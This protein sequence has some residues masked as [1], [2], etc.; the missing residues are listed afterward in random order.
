MG[1]FTAHAG[2]RRRAPRR[3]RPGL[4]HPQ[5]QERPRLPEDGLDRGRAG[6]GE[7]PGPPAPALLLR[8]REDGAT[9]GRAP[10]A[11]A[12]RR[13]PSWS[14]AESPGCWPASRPRPAMPPTTSPTCAGATGRPAARLPGRHRGATAAWPGWPCSGCGPRRAV[15]V[16]RGRGA[17][18]R[19]PGGRPAAAAPGG[20]G[21]RGRPPHLRRP[22]RLGGGP[23]SHGPASCPRRSGSRWSPTRCAPA[24][25]PT[26]SSAPGR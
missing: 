12:R 1:I 6:A 14:A 20:P 24:S 15:G 9:G 21:G 7:D 26:V 22:G 16:D 17:G 4:Q 3:G 11:D 13:P 2:R 25:G 23:G 18:R 8:G 10:A 5:R 19:R